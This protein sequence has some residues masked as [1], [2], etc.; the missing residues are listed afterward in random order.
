MAVIAK[1]LKDLQGKTE[2]GWQRRVAELAGVTAETVTRW[3]GGQGN[4]KLS[5]LE[6][7]ADAL[8]VSVCYL[9]EPTA[10]GQPVLPEKLA[11]ERERAAL[12]RERLA[13]IEDAERRLERLKAGRG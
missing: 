10:R 1:R 2:R 9:I 11:V 8:G 5:E 7:L 6:G 12:E 13:Q 3:K 4:P